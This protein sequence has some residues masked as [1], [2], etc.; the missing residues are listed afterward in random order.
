MAILLWVYTD[1]TKDIGTN[2]NKG[3]SRIPQ[4]SMEFFSLCK[5]MC[6]DKW[7]FKTTNGKKQLMNYKL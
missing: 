2:V 6:W 7:I 1:E 5:L 4:Q 3:T